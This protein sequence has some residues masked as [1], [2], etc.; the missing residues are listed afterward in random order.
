MFVILVL[1]ADVIIWT[2]KKCTLHYTTL[3]IHFVYTKY[4]LYYT[5][6]YYTILYYTILYCTVLYYAML[7]Y[8]ITYLLPTSTEKYTTSRQEVTNFSNVL[9]IIGRYKQISGTFR[10]DI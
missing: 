3:R 10:S 4:T 8:A 7:C 9:F 6:L 1:V 5:I 2:W